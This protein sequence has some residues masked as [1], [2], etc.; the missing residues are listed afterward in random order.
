M[1]ANGRSTYTQED[2]ARILAVLAANGGNIKRTA[3]E[4][5]VP[6]NTV[7]R[8]K[9]QN[10]QGAGPPPAVVAAAVGEFVDE[11]KEVRGMA[12]SLL[13]AKLAAGDVD[14]RTAVTIVGILDDKVRLATGMPTNRTEHVN[15]LPP[16]EE[17][18]GLLEGYGRALLEGATRRNDEIVEAEV[19]AEIP[20]TT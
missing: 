5:G 18:R 17:V 8:W 4:T 3:R 16:V 19:V 2:K 14:A 15:T 9:T 7:R 10:A 13:K 11:A 6:V 20:A 12:L 1:A